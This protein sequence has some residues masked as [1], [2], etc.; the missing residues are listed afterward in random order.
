MSGEPSPIQEGPQ[1]QGLSL[2]TLAAHAGIPQKP[3]LG[4]QK[5]AQKNN[6][7]LPQNAHVTPLFQTTVFDFDSIQ[8]AADQVLRQGGCLDELE[9]SEAV[10]LL[11]VSAS[12]H[13]RHVA[14][15]M[16]EIGSCVSHCQQSPALKKSM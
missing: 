10:A 6:H 16:F 2:A 1:R 13:H 11:T 9:R 5:S 15:C 3:L 8:T 7:S 14:Y 4:G 12:D